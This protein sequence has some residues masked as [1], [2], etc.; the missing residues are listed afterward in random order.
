MQP[1]NLSRSEWS[2]RRPYMTLSEDAAHHSVRL[3]ILAQQQRNL[4]VCKWKMNG[5]GDVN[6][7]AEAYPS[8]ILSIRE[9]TFPVTRSVDR[10]S[11]IF[12][13]IELVTKSTSTPS[14]NYKRVRPHS[15]C[16][17]H[18]RMQD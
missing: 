2:W 15:N 17:Q 8:S 3:P 5:T 14:S 13:G 4:V 10:P 7:T 12:G 16:S 18:V 1:Q 9:M 6:F 11:V